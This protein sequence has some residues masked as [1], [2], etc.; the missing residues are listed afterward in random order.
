MIKLRDYQEPFY[1]NILNE[2]YENNIDKIC[3]LPTGGGKS[4][5]IGKPS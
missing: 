3:D 5:V 1:Q 4:V 2:L